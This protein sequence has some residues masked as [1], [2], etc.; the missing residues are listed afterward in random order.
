MRA[1][2]MGSVNG[3]ATKTKLIY[4]PIESTTQSMWTGPTPLTS[5][6]PE[7]KKKGARRKFEMCS[8]SDGGLRDVGTGK[9]KCSDH[10]DA[11]DYIAEYHCV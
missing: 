5:P 4:I 1:R 11:H 3:P 2:T 9:Y 7:R 6:P 8:V 10:I